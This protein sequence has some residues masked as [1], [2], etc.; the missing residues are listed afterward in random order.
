MNRL[1][2]PLLIL[3]GLVLIG[4]GICF[5]IAAIDSPESAWDNSLSVYV[6]RND[7]DGLLTFLHQNILAPIRRGWTPVVICGVVLTALA[8]FIKVDRKGGDHK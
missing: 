6:P 2:K 7:V 1:L 5:P 4:Y 8:C 3:L